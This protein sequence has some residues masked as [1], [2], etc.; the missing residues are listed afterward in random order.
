LITKVVCGIAS[1][2]GSVTTLASFVIFSE[3]G[4]EGV[5]VD[6]EEGHLGWTVEGFYQQLRSDDFITLLAW[7][8]ILTS[9]EAIFSII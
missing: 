6:A 1:L 8:V 9:L 5:G 3:V 4:V 2:S 7:T